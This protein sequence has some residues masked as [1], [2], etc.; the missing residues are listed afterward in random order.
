MVRNGFITEA[1]M[2]VAAKED[3]KVINGVATIEYGAWW[4]WWKKSPDATDPENAPVPI[5]NFRV[6]RGNEILTCL[7]VVP[8][9]PGDV[10]FIIKNQTTGDFCTFIVVAPGAVDPLGSTAD[11][12][13]ERPNEV[14]SRRT[15]PLPHCT[16]VTFHYCLAQSAAD[17]VSPA[18]TQ[19]LAGNARFINMYERFANP[20]RIAFVSKAA[21]ASSTST[22][23]VY[24]EAGS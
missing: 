22:R 9:T 21:K 12:I 6:H 17:F 11:W 14:G 3:I 8:P 4:Q 5:T 24:H 10:R 2:E 19:S 13:M 16:D 20:H 15:Y 23:I 1:Q 18:V 7:I